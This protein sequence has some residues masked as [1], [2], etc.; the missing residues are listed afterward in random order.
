[1]RNINIKYYYYYPHPV[2][3]ALVSN[4]SK[5]LFCDFIMKLPSNNFY[6][7]I[8]DILCFLWLLNYHFIQ[9]YNIFIFLPSV[10]CEPPFVIEHPHPVRSAHASNRSQGLLLNLTYNFIIICLR[11]FLHCMNCTAQTVW[12]W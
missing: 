12:S 10:S 11:W 2:M 6:H 8:S 7:C 9:S 1:M 3:S 4:P 5:G